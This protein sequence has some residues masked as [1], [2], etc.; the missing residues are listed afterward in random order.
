[1]AQLVRVPACHAGGWGF[2]SPLRRFQNVLETQKRKEKE[3]YTDNQGN[4]YHMLRDPSGKYRSMYFISSAANKEQTIIIDEDL[5]I[6]T[7]SSLGNKNHTE[8]LHTHDARKHWTEKVE[9]GWK[10]QQMSIKDIDDMKVV[11]PEMCVRAI[12]EDQPWEVIDQRINS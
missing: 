10:I 1:V 7:P 3:M 12:H 9:K 2:K 8:I 11:I 6:A 5:A 4:E